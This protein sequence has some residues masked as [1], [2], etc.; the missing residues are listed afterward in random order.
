MG[1]ATDR[2]YWYWKG[3][4]WYWIRHHYKYER[5]VG[6]TGTTTAPGT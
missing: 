2:V 6:R 5:Y 3:G 4:H 1:D